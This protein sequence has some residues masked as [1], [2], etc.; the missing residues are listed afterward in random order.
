MSGALVVA[1]LVKTEVRGSNPVIVEKYMEYLF[2]VFC[3]EKNKIKKKR[4]GMAHLK[5]YPVLQCLLPGMSILGKVFVAKSL[6]KFAL[7]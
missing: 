2:T 1:Q 5:N 4:P 6:L 3:I 7:N